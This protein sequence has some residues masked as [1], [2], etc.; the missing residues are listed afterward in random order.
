MSKF[1]TATEAK[2]YLFAGKATIT[3]KS[4]ASG[5]HYTYRINKSFDG[6]VFFVKVL[7]DSDQYVYVGILRSKDEGNITL[8]QKST[9]TQD[10]PAVK[11]FDYML[12]HVQQNSIPN[13]LEIRHEGTCGR[14]GRQLTHPD[15]IDRGIGPECIKH[16]Y[17]CS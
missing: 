2:A 10:T 13:M 6:H 17:T 12:S 15:S 11:A 7:C 9:M 16:V 1:H 4:L 3:I 8:T 5:N 14:C